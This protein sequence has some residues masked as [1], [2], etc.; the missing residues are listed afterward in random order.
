M[1]MQPTHVSVNE[2]VLRRA[3]NVALM[4]EENAAELLAQ[5]DAKHGRST[6]KNKLLA[7]MLEGDRQNAATSV[8]ELRKALGWPERKRND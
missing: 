4:G 7:A 2:E 6:Q 8:D 5:H 1:M 3:L